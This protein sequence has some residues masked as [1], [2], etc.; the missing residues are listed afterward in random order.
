M[1]RIVSLTTIVSLLLLAGCV[2]RQVH[3]ARI[4]ELNDELMNARE[5]S[6]SLSDRLRN[7]E[8]VSEKFKTGLNDVQAAAE[9][10]K[11]EAKKLQADAA[12]NAKERDDFK[13][14][15]EKLNRSIAGELKSVPQVLVDKKG[16]VQF[17]VQFAIGGTD[18]TAD[19]LKSLLV[20][21]N[22]LAKQDGV[23]YVDG[24][25]DDLPV[26]KPETKKM[27][28]DNLGLSLTRAAVVARTLIEA[29]VAPKRLVVR[30]FGSTQPVA[31]NETLEGQAKN[32]RVEI[33]FVPSKT[34]DEK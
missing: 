1:L 20:I 7:V 29:K 12:K 19:A 18:L 13:K 6:V 4:A 25:S 31:S 2:S 16:A 9:K 5:V 15:Y 23:V 34:N 24:H 26:D 8:G 27:Y 33:H 22:S 11:A 10:L 3:E 17:T 14:K 28:V 30:G 32:R 21:A